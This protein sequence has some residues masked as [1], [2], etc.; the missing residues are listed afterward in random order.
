MVMSDTPTATRCKRC[1]EP[2]KPVD[3]AKDWPSRLRG[4]ITTRVHRVSIVS[5][6]L[7]GRFGEESP[8]IV[9]TEPIDL[10]DECW[11]EFLAWATQPE[12]ERL[13]IAAENRRREAQRIQAA[14]DRRE[15]EIRRLMK[16]G[17]PNDHE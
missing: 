6:I 12:Q 7:G 8:R 9:N 10:C 1:D 15:R 2:V 17:A 5:Y 16:E 3:L 13:K 11:G 14:E 4:K